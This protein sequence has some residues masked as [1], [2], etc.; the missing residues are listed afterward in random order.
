MSGVATDANGDGVASVYEPADA[1]A[2]SAK[3]LLAHGVQNNVSGAIFAYTTFSP[4]CRRCSTGQAS[5]A[6]A[7]TP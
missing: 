6:A 4:T 1:I 7:A 3:Y 5:T 2:G